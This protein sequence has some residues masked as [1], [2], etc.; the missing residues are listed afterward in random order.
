MCF[1]SNTA[2]V[3]QKIDTTTLP[4]CGISRT[5]RIYVWTFDENN[6][7]PNNLFAYQ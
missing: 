5:F 4:Q 1:G 3:K 7:E 2:R 6:K